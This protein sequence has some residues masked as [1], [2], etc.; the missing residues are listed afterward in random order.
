MIGFPGENSEYDTILL[1]CL[2]G[3]A[4]GRRTAAECLAMYPNYAQSLR[5]MLHLAQSLQG[6]QQVRPSLGF[7]T[8]ASSRFQHRLA[9]S[10]RAPHG[11]HQ[12]RSL[13]HTL[14]PRLALR[15]TAVAAVIGLVLGFSSLAAY[16]AD[17]SV[18]GETLY[19]LDLAVEQTQLNFSFT[20]ERS[21]ALEI[22]FA[23]ERLREAEA[24]LSQGSYAQADVALTHYD[25]TI[26]DLTEVAQASNYSSEAAQILIETLSNYETRLR[27]L[28]T[29][30]PEQ[31]QSGIERAIAASVE[32]REK[33]EQHGTKREGGRN[34]P[35]GNGKISNS[36]GASNIGRSHRYNSGKN[37]GGNSQGNGSAGNS[38]KKHGNGKGN[39]NTSSSGKKGGGKGN[40]IQP[41]PVGS[42]NSPGNG[43]ANGGKNGGDGGG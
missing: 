27:A 8:R 14:F 23:D 16:A 40:G 5:P 4:E 24:L 12:P 26:T 25:E 32:A 42:G 11:V 39:G 33:E 9:E 43:N 6:V 20:P 34:N 3:I 31:A 19:S 28:L 2:D 29:K 38:S 17:G 18:P 37:A 30:V 7:R 36:D 41:T 21:Q 13:K 10:N 22:G 1:E 15:F 35:T